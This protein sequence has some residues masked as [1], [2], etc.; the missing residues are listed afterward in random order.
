MFGWD[1][2]AVFGGGP[3]RIGDS[4]EPEPLCGG[5]GG[6]THGDERNHE[7]TT[8]GGRRITAHSV[9]PDRILSSCVRFTECLLYVAR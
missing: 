4:G 7:N 6:H 5:I 8:D 3:E 2:A 9:M 1:G